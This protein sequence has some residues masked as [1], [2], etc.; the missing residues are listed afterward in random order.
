[1]KQWNIA[2]AI[3]VN[4]S[5]CLLYMLHTASNT[6]KH[7]NTVQRKFLTGENF[8]ELSKSRKLTSK[9]LTNAHASEYSN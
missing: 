2:V 4:V 3:P 7:W 8:D 6:F 9:I 5:L 1:M